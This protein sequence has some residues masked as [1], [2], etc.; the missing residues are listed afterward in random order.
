MTPN[1]L[2]DAALSELAELLH[3][4]RDAILQCWSQAARK[5]P[6][7][8]AATTLSRSQF[9]D[10]IP[11]MLD[12][13][14]RRMASDTAAEDR[15]ATC[16]EVANAERH[17]F[18]RWQQGYNEQEVMREWVWLNECLSDEL[19]NYAAANASLAPGVMSAAWRLVSD[20]LV[21][22]MTESISQYVGMQRADASTRLGTLEDAHRQLAALEQQRAEA[23]REATHDLRGN[24]SIVSN[25]ASVLQIQ[26]AAAPPLEKSLR[27]LERSVASL[28][29]LLNDLTTQARLDAGR[30][31]RD[32]GPFDVAQALSDLC[33][34]SQS[35]AAEHGLYLHCK[36]PPSL[37]V[38]GD[39][40]K[41]CRIAQNLVLNAVQYTQQGGIDVSWDA[42]GDDGARW[43]LSVQDSGPGVGA[44]NATRAPAA[45]VAA[46][47]PTSRNGEARPPAGT[48][49]RG[50]GG[51]RRDHEGIGLA[52]VKRLCELLDGRLELESIR[53]Q[54][55]TFRV[56]FPAH[57]PNA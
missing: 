22:G 23:W 6:R 37:V 16:D 2:N 41:V 5:D 27:M 9:F 54:G 52:I 11:D 24:L 30:E 14:E 25:V 10:H 40:V 21:C 18:Q 15:A 20:F 53:D 32:A 48:T 39:R 45:G 28:H 55:S 49:Q 44:S 12:A 3:A 46:D 4:R 33:A 13:L 19:E 50:A 31:R 43:V 36:G 29:A 57:Y 26:A 8:S 47:P 7:I 38:E 51:D 56:T 42:V 1:E 17:G 35:M 34:G